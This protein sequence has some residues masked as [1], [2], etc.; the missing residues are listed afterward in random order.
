MVII[1]SCNEDPTYSEFW[2]PVSQAYKAMFP[3]ATVHLAFLTNRAEDD[4][5][6]MDFR[7]YGKVTLFPILP[8]IPEFGQAKM[9]RFILASQQERETCYIDDID[10]LPLQKDF[11]TSKLNIRPDYVLLCVGAEVYGWQGMC[12][13]SQMTAEGHIWKRFIN[14]KDLGYSDL[15][16]SWTGY[17]YDIRE[18]INIEQTA[19]PDGFKNDIYFSDE[20]LLR[21]LLRENPVPTLNIAR[22]YDNYLDATI[23]RATVVKNTDEWI[24]DREKL[25]VG[26]FVNAHCARPYSQFKTQMEPLIN[27]VSENYG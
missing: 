24:F 7:E 2:K 18:K 11:I 17:F 9:I 21:R 27:Y 14:P 5:L 16:H 25:S 6:V 23:D 3:S 22:G 12:P 15:I 1:L 10:L 26:G 13:V 19:T 4:D 20:R 8:D